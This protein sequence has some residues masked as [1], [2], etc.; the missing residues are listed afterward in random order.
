MLEYQ[1][2]EIGSKRCGITGISVTVLLLMGSFVT[3]AIIGIVISM[4]PNLLNLN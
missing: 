1:G 3:L 4:L 2:E